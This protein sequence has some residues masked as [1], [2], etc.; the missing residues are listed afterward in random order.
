MNAPVII[1]W[2][3]GISQSAF[4]VY[5]GKKKVSEYKGIWGFWRWFEAGNFENNEI[6]F[7]N[8]A[9]K[10][11]GQTESDLN[12]LLILRSQSPANTLL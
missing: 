4:S 11:N 6:A 1:G 12:W 8:H 10:I 5:E 3:A 7:H 2:P 9:F